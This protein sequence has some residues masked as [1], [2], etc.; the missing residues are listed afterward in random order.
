[1]NVRKEVNEMKTRRI[2]QKIVETESFL[3]SKLNKIDKL[4]AKLKLQRNVGF[5]AMWLETKRGSFTDTY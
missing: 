2:I 4:L 5:E 3:L 1:M